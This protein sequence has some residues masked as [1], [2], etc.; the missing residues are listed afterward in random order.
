MELDDI[1]MSHLR[2]D[3]EL[4]S[5]LKIRSIFRFPFAFWICPGPNLLFHFSLIHFR[6]HHLHSKYTA[7]AQQLPFVADSKATLSEER[8]GRV[9]LP[10]FTWFR[11]NGRRR[12]RMV[13]M[14]LGRCC[15]LGSCGRSRIP[16]GL[17]SIHVGFW[18]D[19]NVRGSR[20][21]CFHLSLEKA[22]SGLRLVLK[23]LR[24]GL[25]P[26][27]RSSNQEM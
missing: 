13:W 9:S 24:F 11:D 7:V 14:M 1:R 20:G 17:W 25:N 15:L 23:V 22:R 16:L 19:R 5:K 21:Q 27:E 18:F 6:F 3:L 4:C 2:M 12:S 8:T 10:I 26:R